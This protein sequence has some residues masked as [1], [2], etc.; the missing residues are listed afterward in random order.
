MCKD[1]AGAVRV[2]VDLPIAGELVIL[3]PVFD[4]TAHILRRIAKEQPD[5]VGEAAVGVQA[6]DEAADKVSGVICS[7]VISGPT[8]DAVKM[9]ERISVGRDRVGHIPM[10]A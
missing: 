4:E 7:H 10:N 8:D 9:A 5:L 6:A 1:P 3:R 2:P